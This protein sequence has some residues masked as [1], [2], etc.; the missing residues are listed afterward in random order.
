MAHYLAQ[1]Q[2]K[3]KRK[4]HILNNHNCITNDYIVNQK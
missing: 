1:E 2:K 3:Q 4:A